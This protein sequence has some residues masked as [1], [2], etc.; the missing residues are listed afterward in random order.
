MNA[1]DIFLVT[2][3]KVLPFQFK[4]QTLFVDTFFCVD[5]MAYIV[6]IIL[7]SSFLPLISL[8]FRYSLIEITLHG[9]GCVA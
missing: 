9:E 4:S 1:F 8:V 3:H 2:C 5:V 6:V 7:F